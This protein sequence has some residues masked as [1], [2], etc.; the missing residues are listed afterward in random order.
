MNNESTYALKFLGK[1]TSK[2]EC[3]LI[4]K[5]KYTTYV[6]CLR[7]WRVC[8]TKIREYTKTNEDTGLRKKN[9]QKGEKQTDPR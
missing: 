1:I 2:S 3:K 7:Y 4:V 5:I 6:P 9:T 8:S